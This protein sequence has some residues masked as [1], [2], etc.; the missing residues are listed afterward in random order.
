MHC[1]NIPKAKRIYHRSH[2]VLFCAYDQLSTI[3]CIS[4]YV[5]CRGA[6][7]AGQPWNAAANASL[8]RSISAAIARRCIS[9]CCCRIAKMT[10]SFLSIRGGFAPALHLHV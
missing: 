3:Y 7:S 2:P 10:A 9:C 8:C 4:Q 1:Y 6:A 5:H